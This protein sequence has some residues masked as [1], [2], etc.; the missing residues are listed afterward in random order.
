MAASRPRAPAPAAA[1]TPGPERGNRTV[2]RRDPGGQYR[3][4]AL[5]PRTDTDRAR[6]A[7]QRRRGRAH[8]RRGTTSHAG[9]TF[10][11]AP[12]RTCG[13]SIL[14]GVAGTQGASV[15]GAGIG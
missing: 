2:P 11:R 14:A 3:R 6:A 12:G 8:Q 9:L 10:A 7:A 15:R 13:A 4:A 5:L 1:A